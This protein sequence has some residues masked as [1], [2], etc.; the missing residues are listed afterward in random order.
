MW[1]T[2]THIGKT[3]TNE[4]NKS[5]L[6]KQKLSPVVSVPSEADILLSRAKASPSSGTVTGCVVA[7]KSFTSFCTAVMSPFVLFLPFCRSRAVRIWI[8]L[9]YGASQTYAILILI[10]HFPLEVYLP[11]KA[12]YGPDS[13]LLSL[14]TFCAIFQ[15]DS[16]LSCVFPVVLLTMTSAVLLIHSLESSQRLQKNHSNIDIAYKLNIS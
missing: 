4:M 11:Q 2:Y 1:C 6:K 14:G 7:S 8:C 3:L 16:R 15:I 9:V 10:S 13:L 12:L 5:N